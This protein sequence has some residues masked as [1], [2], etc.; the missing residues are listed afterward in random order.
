MKTY[1]NFIEINSNKRFVRPCIKGTRIAVYDVLSWLSNGMT[2]SNILD[3]F[4]EI[5]EE[6]VLAC[7]AYSADM[8]HNVRVA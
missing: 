6:E 1:S 3:D 4:P 2:I 5:K 7:F 8:E